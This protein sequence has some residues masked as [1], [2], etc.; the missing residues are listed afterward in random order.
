MSHIHISRG[1]KTRHRQ[2]FT[3]RPNLFCGQFCS[4]NM[5]SKPILEVQDLHKTYGD[6][7]AVKGVGFTVYEGDIFGFL[8]PNGAGKS[9]TMRMITSLVKPTMGQIRVFG[10]PLESNREHIM[11]R[12]GVIVEKPDLYGYLSAYDNLKMLASLN[13]K[14]IGRQRIEEVLALVGLQERAK[15]KVKKFSQ[16]MKQRLGIA[17]AL[18]HD[19]ELIVLDEPSNGLDPQGIV[20]IRELVIKLGR[21]MGKT[22][23]LSSHLLSEVELMANRMVIINKGTV[24]VE[25]NVADLLGGSMLKVSVECS[26]SEKAL[27]LMEASGLADGFQKVSDSVIQMEMDRIHVPAIIDMLVKNGISVQSVVPVR[28]L[29]DYFLNLV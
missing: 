7:Q 6:F 10:L 12:M 17:Q 5:T 14:K 29:E 19:P 24:S 26:S 4:T 23:I 16:G 1:L 25:G 28:K 3:S 21:E 20:D 27:A 11:S 18:I 13:Q 22:V 2:Y 8:G 15:D 9:T